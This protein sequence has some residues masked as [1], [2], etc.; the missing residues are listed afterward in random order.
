MKKVASTFDVKSVMIGMLGTLLFFSILGS[1]ST[2][3]NVSGRY[4]A[5]SSERGFIILDTQTGK[6]ILDS[7]VN[8]IGKIGWIKGEFESS[9]ERGKSKE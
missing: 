1:A 2:Q 8:Y 7:N 4:Q 5:S 3:S 9:F 6:Y